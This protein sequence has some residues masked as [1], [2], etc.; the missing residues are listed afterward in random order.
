MSAATP[1]STVNRNSTLSIGINGNY[2][3][4]ANDQNYFTYGQGGYFSP[5]SF[6]SISF[7][8]HYN[9]RQPGGFEV[10][11]NAAPGYQSY[12]QQSTALYP[13]DTTAQARLDALKAL[14]NDVRSRFDSISQ[15]GFGLAAGGSV[16]YPLN[17]RMKVGGEANYNT[18]GAYNEFRG[19]VGIKQVLG[20]N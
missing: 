13:T 2:Q 9:L 8:L 15:T 18:F 7:P 10:D 3:D 6:L 11:V 20:G 17:P 16:Y 14:N 5:Q 19:S 4:Y 12:N 1:A